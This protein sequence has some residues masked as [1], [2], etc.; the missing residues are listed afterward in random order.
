[1]SRR[2]IIGAGSHRRRWNLA[3]LAFLL[4]VFAFA[5]LINWPG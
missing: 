2:Q 5:F 3:A 4:I 1:V